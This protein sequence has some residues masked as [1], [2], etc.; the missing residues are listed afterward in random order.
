MKPETPKLKIDLDF[1]SIKLPI[2]QRGF[3]TLESDILEHGCQKPITVWHGFIADGHS[4]YEI[5]AKHDIPF[6][7]R[8]LD[9]EYREEVLTWICTEQ[10]QKKKISEEARKFL[11][12]YQYLIAKSLVM[13]KKARFDAMRTDD[14]P[15]EMP[16]PNRHVTAEE[17][18][19]RNNVS[20][21]TVLKY[22]T[23]AR[24]LEI[25]EQKT[26]GFIAK[27]LSGKYK[28]SHAN[29]VEISRHSPAEIEKISS[30]L[31]RN[32]LPYLQYNKARSVLRNTATPNV[33][34]V[35]DMPVYDPDAPLT[36]LALTI[37]SWIS[38][39]NRAKNN[40]DLSAVS[41]AA[42][43]KLI[44]MLTEFHEIAEEILKKIKEE[45]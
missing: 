25:I 13:R 16:I 3:L 37:P 39:L 29:I 4:R 23:Y 43:Q 40:T 1:K 8:E 24:A 26:P 35:K 17:I 36:E 10:L 11:I 33:P 28:I 15:D 12:G 2:S 9:Y 7:V 18:G 34:S 30:K 38:S 42:K 14:D 20:Y 32:G 44:A 19:E 27:I 41:A 22:S 45:E 6:R 21:S 5:C 31:E